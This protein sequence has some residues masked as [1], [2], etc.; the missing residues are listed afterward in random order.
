MTGKSV[1]IGALRS[2]KRWIS[3]L[4]PRACR[5]EPTCS[6]Y[7]TDAVELY[8]AWRGSGMAL[9]RLMRCHPFSRGGFDPVPPPARDRSGSEPDAETTRCHG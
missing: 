3:P 4:L 7:A 6:E 2:Y 8:G 1:V 9:K 5:F